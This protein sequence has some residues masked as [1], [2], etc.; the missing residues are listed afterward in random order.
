MTQDTENLILEHLRAIR[1]DVADTRIDIG[2][3]KLRQNDMANAIAGLR[4]NQAGDAGVAVHLQ[5]QIDRLNDRVER[6]NRRLDIVE[7]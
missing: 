1:S 2:D 7:A 4:R 6:I 3:I 5:V